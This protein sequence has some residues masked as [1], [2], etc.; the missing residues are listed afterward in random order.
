M[1]FVPAFASASRERWAMEED[2]EEKERRA[3]QR[4]I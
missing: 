1:Q 2:P 4:E 3:K